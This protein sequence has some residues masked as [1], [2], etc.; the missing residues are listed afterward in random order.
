MI[1]EDRYITIKRSDL[2]DAVAK[3]YLNKHNLLMLT[4]FLDKYET[5]RHNQKVPLETVVVEKDWPEYEVVWKLIQ[6]RVDNTMPIRL[7]DFLP[8]DVV[9]DLC[10]V[11]NDAAT[12]FPGSRETPDYLVNVAHFMFYG[13]SGY[14]NPT[15]PEP[16]AL[17]EHHENMVKTIRELWLKNYREDLTEDEKDRDVVTPYDHLLYRAKGKES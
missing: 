3:G 14:P 4:C 13:K 6:A 9:A 7:F 1:R 12:L 15:L 11:M 17:V 5:Y 2:D 8:F 16:E 10:S